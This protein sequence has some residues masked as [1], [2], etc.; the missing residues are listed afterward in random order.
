MIIKELLKP[1]EM[2]F[3]DFMLPNR[4]KVCKEYYIHLVHISRADGEIGPKELE[5]LHKEGRKFGLTDPEIDNLIE[6]E[7]DHQY[8]PPY[9]LTGKFNHLYNI[10]EMILADDVVTAQEKKMIT[11]FAIEAG[12]DDKAVPVLVD[13][14]LEGIE[15]GK[16][17]EV[18]LNEFRRDHLYK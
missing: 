4:K 18:L 2:S 1:I 11:R 7:K 5:F 8:T 10:A 14:L 13:H 9:S 17:E 3:A 6:N 16:D 12:F 15:A